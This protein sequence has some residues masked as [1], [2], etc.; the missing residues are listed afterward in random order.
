MK[1]MLSAGKVKIIISEV[2]YI[3]NQEIVLKN[4]A[5]LIKKINRKSILYIFEWVFFI[6]IALNIIR[7]KI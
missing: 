4:V 2:I 6:L 7:A 1:Y 3:K 5:P